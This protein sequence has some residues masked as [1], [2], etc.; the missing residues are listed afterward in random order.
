MELWKIPPK[1]KI[2]EALSA[3]SDDRVK[4]KGDTIAEVVSSSGNKTYIVEWSED[5]ITANDNASYWQG[6]MGYPILAI[7]MTLGKIHFNRDVATLLSG[8]PWKTINTKYR[9][10]YE[11]A[12][13]A[14]LD[15]IRA[16][17]QQRKLIK[18]EID[19]IMN[20]IMELQFRKLP[21]RR[22]PPK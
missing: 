15:F 22:Q 12:I 1:A 14:A 3:V 17:S 19:N 4:K 5:S 7:L 8:I 6:Y 11:K 16:S 2:Y 9:N 10:N 20:Q 18:A 21:K 13:A